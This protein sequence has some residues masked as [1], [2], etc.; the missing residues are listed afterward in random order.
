MT[1][2]ERAT[3]AITTPPTHPSR[4]FQPRVL[5]R[6]SEATVHLL[7]SPLYAGKPNWDLLSTVSPH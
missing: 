5:R 1:A 2:G 3:R 7:R 4:Y 6:P